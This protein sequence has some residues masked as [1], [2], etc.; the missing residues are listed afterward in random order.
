MGPYLAIFQTAIDQKGE[1]NL[2]GVGQLLRGDSSWRLVWRRDA[3][4]IYAGGAHALARRATPDGRGL[5]LGDVFEPGGLAAPDVV[6]LDPTSPR[7]AAEQLSGRYWGRY[8]FIRLEDNGRVSSVFRDPS[9]A[10]DALVC[11][12]GGLTLVGSELPA[13]LLN[14]LGLRVSVDWT[15]LHN[16]LLDIGLLTAESA[17]LGLRALAPGAMLDLTT[18][19]AEA[20][21]IWRPELHARALCTDVGAARRELR[22]RVR[23]CVAALARGA[24]PILAEI[25]GGLDSSIVATALVAADAPVAGWLHHIASDPG[26]DERAFAEALAG[27]Y[28]LTLVLCDKGE[29]DFSPRRLARA[30]NGVRPSINGL[31]DP[32]DT[33]LI[34]TGDS[35]DAGRAFSGHGGDGLFYQS[36]DFSIA[37]DFI[38]R[39]GAAAF[40]GIDFVDLARWLR[41]SIWRLARI[42]LTAREPKDPWADVTAPDWIAPALGARRVHP[43]LRDASDLPPAKRRHIEEIVH[44]LL[45]HG[46]SR[47]GRR[48]DLVHPLLSQPVIEH[49][50]SLP[51]DLLVQGGRDRSLAR[52]AFR[53]DLP[54]SV[55][56]RRSKGELGAYYSRAV[57]CALP[58]LRPFLLDG[59]LAQHGLIL[60]APLERAL[61]EG[62]L[63][64]RSGYPMILRAAALEAWARHWDGSGP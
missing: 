22:R 40:A 47:R 12:R 32:Y 37:I 19:D 26:G 6:D 57:V 13:S 41:I 64:E 10:M 35:L 2:R 58:K 49:C 56:D 20:V 29:A 61:E 36:P 28:G 33:V 48:F 54:S 1:L 21:Q 17:L 46:A 24:A 39:R 23:T 27:R 8:V 53:A 34:A 60:R 25:S 55:L 15:V 43:W 5:I 31:D 18:V 44:A 51:V 38:R 14:G 45:Y 9:G 62:Y 11:S 16:Q 59:L 4:M 42:G 63:T 7:R 52:Q 3:W 30:A 50:L